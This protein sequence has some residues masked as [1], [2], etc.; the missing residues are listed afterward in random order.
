[1]PARPL[2]PVTLV[3]DH[4]CLEPLTPSH[5]GALAAVALDP[6]LWTWTVSRVQTRDDL[7]AYI[8]TA[9]DAQAA[10]TALPF[11]IV[12]RRG[13]TVAGSTR[14]GNVAL[15]HGRLEIGWTWIGAPWQRTAVNTEAKRLL[16]R[17]AFETLG[18]RR[19][20]F[21]TDARNARSRRAIAALGAQEEGTLRQHTVT[22]S[23]FLRDTVYFSILADEWP[24]VDARLAARLA[25]Y[26]DR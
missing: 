25:R 11:V 3:G 14:Y 6:D 12:E 9:L 24:A 7:A 10:G 8:Q 20:E 17:H 15:E 21:K 18:V 5:L 16:L 4:V 26:A 1:M 22:A 13:G 2:Q 19:V 23:G